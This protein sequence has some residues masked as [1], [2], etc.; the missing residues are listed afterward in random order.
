MSKKKTHEEFIQDFN[1]KGNQ[2]ILI[3]G[4]YV[5]ATTK[6]LV[7][8][9]LDGYEWRAYPNDLL[10]GK[11]CPVC[12]GQVVVHGI[13]S[14]ATVRPDLLIYFVNPEDATK[15]TVCSKQKLNLK[16]PDC[17]MP[18]VTMT[19]DKLSTRG[20]SCSN[21]SDGVSFPNKFS[22]ALLNQL[23]VDCVEHEYSPDWLKP[24]SYDNYFEY[25][26]KRYVLEMD[27]EIGHG[28]K[29]FNSV[30]KDID[31][32]K[33]DRFKD[34]LAVQRHITV[35]RIDCIVPNRKYIVDNFLNSKMADLFDLDKVDWDL[36][37][38]SATKSLVKLVCNTYLENPNLSHVVIAK[39]HGVSRDTVR[40]YLKLGTKL[41]WCSYDVREAIKNHNNSVSKPVRV[42]DLNRNLIDTYPSAV[43]CARILT[44]LYG[45]RFDN[46]NIGRAA[47]FGKP[48]HDLYFEYA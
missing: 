25:R 12:A 5:N 46:T 4:K 28:N 26:G 24:Y 29:R 6:I 8:C 18:K 7:K 16:C 32:L 48:Y 37:E 41:G 14:L 43:K 23:Q 11:G 19:A 38:K 2:N 30:E 27:G 13:N 39:K 42:F 17:G 34:A 1:A 15:I 10:Q 47:K 36:C 44:E 22:R 20:F 33:R 31:G 9:L 40:K 3:L 35:I 45:I 21:C